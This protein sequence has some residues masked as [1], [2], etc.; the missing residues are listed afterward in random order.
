M[1]DRL[2]TLPE[3]LAWRAAVTPD[4][5]FLQTT[6]GETVTY[7]Q[8]HEAALSVAGGLQEVGIKSGDR[9]VSMQ[10]LHPT[11]FA[12]WLGIA[13]LRAWDVPVH[14]GARGDSLTYAIRNVEATTVVTDSAF[15][16]QIAEIAHDLP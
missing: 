13:H 7:R 15:L 10:D 4:R 2:Q 6:S 8:Q 3:T 16:P 5:V 11:A 12:N 1:A 9:V 14:T